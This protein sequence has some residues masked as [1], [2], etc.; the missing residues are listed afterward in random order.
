MNAK[1]EFKH[2]YMKQLY[3]EIINSIMD[4]NSVSWVEEKIPAVIDKLIP[5]H[6]INS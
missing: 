6:I 5:M 4:T 2:D 1:R 3:D